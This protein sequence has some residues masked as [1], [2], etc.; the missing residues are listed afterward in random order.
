MRKNPFKIGARIWKTV[1]AVFL[2]F[3]IYS[4][5]GSGGPFYAAIA[6]VLCLQRNNKDSFQT[7]KDRE[8][9]TLIGGVCGMLFLLF[10]K[11]VYAFP[12]EL[13]RYAV[14]ALLLAPIIQIS[15]L[16]RQE[17]GTYLMC[18][19]FLSVVVT[20][21]GDVSPVAFSISRMVDT[22]IGIVVALLVNQLPLG[23]K[24]EEREAEE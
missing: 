7:A 18:V 22:T 14:I 21:A 11:N 6:A 4:L 9:A 10:E 3:G 17:K 2:C 15:V 24:R 20:H 8:I 1:I 5:I 16:L 12:G 19:V 13:P 23:S